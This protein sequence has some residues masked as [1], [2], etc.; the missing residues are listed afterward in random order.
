MVNGINGIPVFQGNP[1][2]L[3]T[4][5]NASAGQG[6]SLV[7]QIIF[8]PLG[9]LPSI[10]NNSLGASNSIFAASMQ[11][12][13]AMSGI[14]PYQNAF[15]SQAPS[16]NALKALNN[17]RSA[18]GMNNLDG[19]FS[20]GKKNDKAWCIDFVYSA[21]GGTLNKDVVSW[22]KQNGRFSTKDELMA[23]GYQGVTP[24][25][26]IFFNNKGQLG[27][28]GEDAKYNNSVNY[29]NKPR[30]HMAIVE[31]VDRARG[32]ITTIEGNSFRENDGHGNSYSVVRRLTYSMRDLETLGGIVRMS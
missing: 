16:E 9:G 6:M 7:D 21:Y 23:N 18:I 29:S 5:L 12:V 26:I 13:N 25:D 14:M 20:G 10:D 15:P 4:A 3:T 22:A 31:S 11:P 30:F 1:I 32:T 24:G 28:V 17:A 27:L 2:G 19:R 8:N